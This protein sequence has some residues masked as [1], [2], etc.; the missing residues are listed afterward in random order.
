[1]NTTSIP[2]DNDLTNG[3]TVTLDGPIAYSRC[4]AFNPNYYINN[5]HFHATDLGSD[6][7]VGEYTYQA[8]ESITFGPNIL[9]DP[10]TLVNLKAPNVINLVSP[11]NV[12]GALNVQLTGCPGRYSAAGY[13]S[14]D[15][16]LDSIF[17]IMP[18]AIAFPN[19]SN[20]GTFTIRILSKDTRPRE[21]KAFDI[22]GKEV[23]ILVAWHGDVVNVEFL[24]RVSGIYNIQIGP[25]L[26]KSSLRVCVLN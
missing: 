9:T 15:E 12:R 11:L 23:R 20:S 1:M 5:E 21:V 13:Y 3:G 24:D 6:G 16:D 26:R 7:I 14:Q 10:N 25:D 17:S 18:D 4:C 22:Y 8:S 2:V 19:P